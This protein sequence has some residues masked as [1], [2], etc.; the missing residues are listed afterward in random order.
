MT[1]TV[2]KDC[3]KIDLT[4]NILAEYASASPSIQYDK[5]E[6]YWSHNTEDGEA[7]LYTV[8]VSDINTDTMTL[9]PTFFGSESDKLSDGIYCFKLVGT[10]TSQIDIEYSTAFVYCGIVCLIA[11]KLWND[12]TAVFYAQFEAIKYQAECV[13]CD[14]TTAA[15][16]F[17]DLLCIIDS[18]PESDCGC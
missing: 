1:A 6:L 5:V 13:E 8:D 14:C 9:D 3:T 4:S 16:L 15:Q 17:K 11:E 12:P 2:D 7:T 10:N 18:N